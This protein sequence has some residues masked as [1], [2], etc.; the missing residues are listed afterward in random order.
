MIMKIKNIFSYVLFII[1][2]TAIFVS[3]NSDDYK[4]GTDAVSDA[5]KDGTWRVSYLYKSGVEK[6]ANYTGYNFV[7]GSS[8]ILSAVKETNSYSGQWFVTKSTSDADLFSTIFKVSIGPSEIF[9]DLNADWKVI[10]NKD[11]SLTLKDDS[12]GDTAISYLTF[13]KI[14]Q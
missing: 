14:E 7:F 11:N 3:C 1:F 13:E 9:Q 2:V 6:T 10:E 8:N 4:T 5:L 12:R